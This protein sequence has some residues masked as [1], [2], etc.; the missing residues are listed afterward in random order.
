M[1]GS[2]SYPA[3]AEKGRQ[4]MVR[5]GYFGAFSMLAAMAL[6]CALAGSS[7][8]AP[9]DTTR[10]G[11]G[12]SADISTGGRYVVFVSSDASNLVEG[13]TNGFG[14]KPDFTAYDKAL[15]Q[16]PNTAPSRK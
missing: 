16:A 5:K 7:T 13:D 1:A 8:A 12:Y 15:P 10:V 14:G 9:G 11:E 3:T 6:L 2:C 4:V